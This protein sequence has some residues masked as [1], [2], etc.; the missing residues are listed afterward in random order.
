MSNKLA[1]KGHPTR[2]KEVIELLKMMGG[3]DSNDFKCRNTNRFYHVLNEHV[4]WGYIGPEEIDEY[5]IFTLEEFLEKFPY[6][7][8][9]KVNSPCKGCVKTITSMK[10]DDYL[11]TVSYKLDNKIYTTI[12][13]L[14]VVNDLPY[15]EEVNIKD[16]KLFEIKVR[17]DTKE[18][19]YGIILLKNNILLFIINML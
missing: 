4:C 18:I 5:N 6:K 19:N 15:K 16:N 14:K 1:I 3:K 2:S 17:P 7:V 9:D 11:N 13:Q 8:G 10:W 12:E